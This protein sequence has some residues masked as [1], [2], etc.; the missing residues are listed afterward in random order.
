MQRRV[1][2]G[3]ELQLA[4]G[5]EVKGKRTYVV[6][7]HL[8]SGAFSA[9]YRA[10]SG[11]LTVA[12]KEY[13]LLGSVPREQVEDVVERELAALRAVGDHEMI[14]GLLEHFQ[15]GRYAYVVRRY[16]EGDTL[17]N[18][19]FLQG[20]LS[21]YQIARFGIGLGMALEYLHRR[22]LVLLDLKPDNVIVDH[23]QVPHIVDLGSVLSL[24]AGAEEVERFLV[25]E[26][27]FAPELASVKGRLA[28]AHPV[29]DVFALG[30]VL[31]ELATGRRLEVEA[32]RD[33]G[34]AHLEPL[35]AR[36][37]LHHTL[38]GVI[39]KALS[40]QAADRFGRIGEMVSELRA[41]VPP[42]LEIYPRRMQLGPVQA[43]QEATGRM[44]IY[45]LGG[46]TL[47]GQVTSS[48][49]WCDVRIGSRAEL[50][51]N[52]YRSNR[53]EVF[54]KCVPPA[55]P[56]GS[57]WLSAYVQVECQTAAARIPVAVQVLSLI[58][59]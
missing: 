47:M 3:P 48:A 37:D 39:G 22:G 54:L 28:Q 20:L 52:R 44:V 33:L 15:E 42:C 41:G 2:R 38:V 6:E 8:G 46:E 40:R 12:I 13:D 36:P 16:V 10:S 5:S 59:I 31:Y 58:H 56:E 25:S 43:G 7:R 55:P 29:L 14:P 21:G 1:R 17:A 32:V 4:P 57:A 50:H 11:A 19:L 35:F 49:P 34:R 9:V 23:S 45:N 26:G 24:E 53:E 18:L 30:A 27:Y 51:T